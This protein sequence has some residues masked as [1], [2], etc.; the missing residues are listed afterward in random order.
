M[1]MLL[2]YTTMFFHRVRWHALHAAA[3]VLYAILLAGS[4][5]LGFVIG[6]LAALAAMALTV[7]VLVATIVGLLTIMG[8]Y[9]DPLHMLLDVAILALLGLGFLFAIPMYLGLRAMTRR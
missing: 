4:A 6:G 7:F 2:R 9:R 1:L 5:V 3:R 8:A